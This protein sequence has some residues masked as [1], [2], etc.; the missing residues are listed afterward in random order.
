[1]PWWLSGSLNVS[2]CPSLEQCPWPAW[3]LP[4]RP[5]LL[6]EDYSQPHGDLTSGLG[7]GPSVSA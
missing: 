1:M 4:A 3:W 6:A 5:Q 7:Q 2:V